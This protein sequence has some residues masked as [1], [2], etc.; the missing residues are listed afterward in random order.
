MNARSAPTFAVTLAAL[1]SLATLG[2]ALVSASPVRADDMTGAFMHAPPDGTALGIVNDERLAAMLGKYVP[3]TSGAAALAGQVVFFGLDMQTTWTTGGAAATAAY[4]A[5]LHVGF[6]LSEAGH[7]VMT[8]STAATEHGATAAP[9][10]PG[11]GT[12]VGDVAASGASGLVQAIAIAGNGN[13]V[14]NG[15]TVAVSTI[16]AKPTVA[17]ASGSVACD[18]CSF[19]TSGGLGIAIHLPD[20]SSASQLVGPGGIAQTARIVSDGN[21]VSNQLQLGLGV[22]PGAPHSFVPSVSTGLFAPL[23]HVGIH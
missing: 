18:A 10:L 15:A 12:I 22:A 6:D 11:A 20:G 9:P 17:S 16:V 13:V 7:P 19:T 8:I 23:P 4:A 1:A 3:E 5:D 2:F 14:E 21:V